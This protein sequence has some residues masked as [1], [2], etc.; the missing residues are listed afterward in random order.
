MVISVPYCNTLVYELVNGAMGFVQGSSVLLDT[1]VLVW[2]YSM[3]PFPQ[4]FLRGI[5][6]PWTSTAAAAQS[7]PGCPDRW[8]NLKAPYPFGMAKGCY[9]ADE[10]FHH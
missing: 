4:I 5:V 1:M 2:F 3:M 9:L 6:I 7:L 10:I 8:G